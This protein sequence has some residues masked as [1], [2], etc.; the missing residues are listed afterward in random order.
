MFP[1]YLGHSLVSHLGC[2]EL[3][4]PSS[5][6]Y[7]MAWSLSLSS[8][9]RTQFCFWD[10]VQLLVIWACL[11]YHSSCL[12]TSLLFLIFVFP[13][14]LDPIALRF[15]HLASLA[16]EQ[17]KMVISICPCRWQDLDWPYS[18]SKLLFPWV[19]N[20]KHREFPHHYRHASTYPKFSFSF[21]AFHLHLLTFRILGL[22]Y[23]VGNHN[24]YLPE[25]SWSVFLALFDLSSAVLG[26]H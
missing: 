11:K 10:F 20:Y 19:T 5:N 7:E 16:R 9:V 1:W 25:E 24:L 23:P 12:L 17:T 4:R 6:W 13:P 26:L 8:P 3:L 15:F 14:L 21:R 18:T 2:T 22:A